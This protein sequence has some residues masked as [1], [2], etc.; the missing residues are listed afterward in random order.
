ME[1]QAPPG[2]P[3]T[4]SHSRV[5]RA[6]PLPRR[7]RPSLRPFRARPG[8]RPC[9][10]RAATSSSGSLRPLSRRWASRSCSTLAVNGPDSGPQHQRDTRRPGTRQQQ[11]NTEHQSQQGCH[12][13]HGKH[14]VRRIPEVD[15]RQELSSALLRLAVLHRRW[16]HHGLEG[17]RR[18]VAHACQVRAHTRWS[19]DSTNPEV[20]SIGYS[21]SVASHAIYVDKLGN[22]FAN[23]SLTSTVNFDLFLDEYDINVPCTPAVPAFYITDSQGFASNFASGGGSTTLPTYIDSRVK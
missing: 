21:V 3:R 2:A 6:H 18:L 17:R 10:W 20:G 23:E 1:I 14:R 5:A 15:V 9:L 11:R 13:H 19:P 22:R 8:S 16:R 12:S 4:K 7:P